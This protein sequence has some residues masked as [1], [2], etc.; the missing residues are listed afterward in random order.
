VARPTGT[1]STS[2]A[3]HIETRQSTPFGDHL[4]NNLATEVEA[5][6]LGARAHLPALADGR[7]STRHQLWG[8][9]GI[10]TYPYSGSAIVVWDSGA[11]AS[12]LGNVAPKGGKDPHE[13]PRASKLAREQKSE[14]LSR[15]GRV[16]DV[17]GGKP[18]TAAPV[19]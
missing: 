9:E 7:S 8:I 13:D 2:P 12:P 16:I 6:V 18:C 14:F 3:T 4:V 15:N 5:R 19:Q 17:C 11:P 10:D 1:R